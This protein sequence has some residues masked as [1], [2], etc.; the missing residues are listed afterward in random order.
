M[1]TF[2]FLLLLG[3]GVA[4]WVTSRNA[5]QSSD[6]NRSLVSYLDQ[7]LQATRAALLSRIDVLEAQVAELQTRGVAAKPTEPAQ[8]EPEE[9]PVAAAA[10]RTEKPSVEEPVVAAPSP[11]IEPPPAQPVVPQAPPVVPS[12]P[13]PLAQLSRRIDWEEWIGVKGAAV[14][15]GIVLAL[16]AVMFLRY[17]IEHELI[18]PMVR[19]A[20]GFATGIAAIA[21][22][23]RLRSREFITMANALAGAGIVVLY[24]SSWAARV[25]Y[26][27]VPA[28]LGFA[29]MILVTVACGALAWR[30]KAREVA[31][32]GLIGGFATPVLMSTGSDNPIGLFGYVLLLDIGLIW[33]ARVRRWPLLMILALFGTFFYEAVWILLR[34]GDRTEIGLGVLL[35]FGL[36]FSLAIGYRRSADDTPQQEGVQRLVQGAGAWAP[37][38]LAFYFA[39]RADLGDHLYPVAGLM[40]VL[41]IASAWL[42]RTEQMPQLPMG[43]AAGCVGVVTVW[44]MRSNFT[45]AL[46][47]EASAVCVALAAAFHIFLELDAKRPVEPGRVAGALAAVTTSLGFLGLLALTA[48]TA[49]GT[50]LWPWLSGWVL[51]AGLALRQAG[52]S[53]WGLGPTGSRV[54]VG[55]W[56]LAFLSR[57]S[58]ER[59]VSAGRPVFRSGHSLRSRVAGT[60][61]PP[62]RYA[63][64]PNS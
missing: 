25:L 54:S 23:E 40:F 26:E 49:T 9:R 38:A 50:P 4:L 12:E 10:P 36:F 17:A 1:E 60:S 63:S 58:L 44:L 13:P 64:G 43:A 59:V 21:I 22:S 24:V 33:L 57:G 31:L 46:A 19:V 55:G 3:F 2:L 28:S 51:L 61:R 5:R 27:L 18:P 47:W 45:T 41:S 53:D 29:L 8:P 48:F 52:L 32:L 35:L 34:M 15:G 56:F 7:E 30:H 16:A 20:I 37:F 62:A 11:S 39:A 42:G 14:L 6:R